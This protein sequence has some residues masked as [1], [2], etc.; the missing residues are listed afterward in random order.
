MMEGLG[1]LCFDLSSAETDF[2]WQEDEHVHRGS[3]QARVYP[4]RWLSLRSRAKAF[5]LKGRHR[6]FVGDSAV[7]TSLREGPLLVGEQKKWHQQI[8][9]KVQNL[10]RHDYI[11]RVLY[12]LYCCTA[13][14][15]CRLLLFSSNSWCKYRSRSLYYS[16]KQEGLLPV[17]MN[18]SRKV[19]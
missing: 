8:L 10:V 9:Q 7:Q 5:K 19:C 4:R 13:V 16:P 6:R 11:N 18:A 12:S 14:C 17:T 3:G 2:W 1:F 15:T